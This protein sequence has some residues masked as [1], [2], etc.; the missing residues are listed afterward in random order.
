MICRPSE[1][2]FEKNGRTV[3]WK[4]TPVKSKPRFRDGGIVSENVSRLSTPTSQNEI[5]RADQE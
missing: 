5:S 4:V 2:S 1:K 3:M